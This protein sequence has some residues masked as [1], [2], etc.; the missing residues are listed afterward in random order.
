MRNQR[1]D[2][3]HKKSNQ[4]IRAFG[5]I[6]LE[7]LNIQGMMQNRKLALAIGEVGWG[8]FK[9][10]LEY[11]AECY[12]KNIRYVGRFEPTSKMCSDCG[13]IFKKLQLKDRYWTCTCCGTHHDR[14]INAAKNIKAI[15]LRNEPSTV[16][17][18]QLGMR[19]G[20]EEAHSSICVSG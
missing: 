3:L 5:T 15:G 9:S 11:K 4:I 8:K 17:V 20:C 10:M 12:G 13:Y 6:C 7:D 14:D 16:N 2:Y 18:G 1:D 19:L